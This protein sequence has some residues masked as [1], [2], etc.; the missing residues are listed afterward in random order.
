[1][2]R[3]VGRV[4]D[5]SE[6]LGRVGR[7]EDGKAST[8]ERFLAIFSGL[9]VAT[10]ES[11]GLLR[12]CFRSPCVRPSPLVLG[13]RLKLPLPKRK[14]PKL[15][16]RKRRLLSLGILCSLLRN[17]IE[18]SSRH[19]LPKAISKRSPMGLGGRLRSMH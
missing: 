9:A 18:K 13:L 19:W 7:V 1:M 15:L 11:C 17:G 3:R 10:L 6:G 12:S 16:P 8:W 5:G 14:L 2:L 4:E